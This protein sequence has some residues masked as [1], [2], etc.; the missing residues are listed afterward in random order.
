MT[1]SAP[2]WMP[3]KLQS[4]AYNVLNV[5]NS[6]TEA[7]TDVVLRSPSAARESDAGPNLVQFWDLTPISRIYGAIRFRSEIFAD[8]PA[9]FRVSIYTVFASYLTPKSVDMILAQSNSSPQDYRQCRQWS[10]L[11]GLSLDYNGPASL[12]SCYTS[13]IYP[14]DCFSLQTQLHLDTSRSTGVTN[15]E[16]IHSAFK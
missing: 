13:R 1:N 9:L 2:C 7:M 8:L 5:L 4:C 10:A 3:I 11:C 12:A 15:K 16:K 14:S 6:V